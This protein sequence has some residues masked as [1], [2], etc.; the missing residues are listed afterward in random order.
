MTRDE[1]LT[2][3]SKLP[4]QIERA[5][6]ALLACRQA[7]DRQEEAARG[8][9]AALLLGGSIDGKN[10]ESRAAQLRLEMAGY[11]AT[12]AELQEKTA[13]AGIKLRR[14]Q[15]EFSAAKAAARLLAGDGEGER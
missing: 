11:R 9:E 2:A 15:A 3:L 7:E 4:S 8:A 13:R 6:L 14:L 5:E 10:Q 12:A 1:I